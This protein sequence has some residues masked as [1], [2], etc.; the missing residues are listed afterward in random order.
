MMQRKYDLEWLQL[1]VP[2]ALTITI[3]GGA[4]AFAF[5]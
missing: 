3:I 5:S 4:F 2:V 1:V